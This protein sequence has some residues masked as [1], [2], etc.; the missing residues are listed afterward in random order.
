MSETTAVRNYSSLD[1]EKVFVTIARLRKRISERFPGSGLSA[2]CAELET[3]CAITEERIQWI[4]KPLWLLRIVRYF[5]I[6]GI[7]AA[8]AVALVQLGVGGFREL[9][10]GE[11]IQTIEAALNNVILIGV[12]IFFLWSLETRV[13]RR[14]ALRSLHELRSIAHVIDMHQLTKDPDRLS[15]KHVRTSSSPDHALTPYELRRYLDYCSE[16]LSLTGK[17]AAL[18]LQTL[19]EP[20]VVSTAREIEDLTTGLSRKIW[21]KIVFLRPDPGSEDSPVFP[22]S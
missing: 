19:D 6:A 21:Q 9:G 8:L 18:Y 17:V 11:W 22:A 13:K 1:P 20:S 2:V 15:K 12:A 7:F 10:V 4:A 5:L 14:R 16:M 3:V